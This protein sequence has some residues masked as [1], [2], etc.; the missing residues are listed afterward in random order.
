MVCI[1]FPNKKWYNYITNKE[2]KMKKSFPIILTAILV[3]AATGA[4]GYF[5]AQNQ[6]QKQISDTQKQ[7][8]EKEKLIK[9][10]EDKIKE[11]EKETEGEESDTSADSSSGTKKQIVSPKG[12]F[13]IDL[14]Q[15][16]DTITSPVR[17]KGWANVFEAQFQVR[18]KDASGNTLATK[19]VMASEGAPNGGTFDTTVTFTQP[20]TKQQGTIEIYD[21]SQMD[22]SIDDIAT[23]KVTLKAK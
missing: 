20:T 17:I 11:L 6:G 1:K 13:K 19:S 21:T 23:I 5:Y 16:G 22:G 18:I 14:P 10:K 8:D 15:S 9:E 3:A 2:G 7:I 12:L 4:G